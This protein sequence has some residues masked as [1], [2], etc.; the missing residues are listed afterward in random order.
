MTSIPTR[1]TESSSTIIDHVITDDY[2]FIIIPGEIRCDDGLSNHYVVFCNHKQYPMILLNHENN[3][4]FTI[5][6]KFN[7]Q[8]DTY[9]EMDRS[10]N[11]FLRG[12]DEFTDF[13]FDATFDAFE[14]VV[15][16]VI[17]NHAVLNDY[18]AKSKNLKG[19]PW[20]TRTRVQKAFK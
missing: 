2:A 17:E 12:I 13:S 5:R 4:F 7:F 18:R 16:S 11:K 10:V 9:E 15:H 1:V 6:D 19:K 20:I 14:S 8:A 3:R